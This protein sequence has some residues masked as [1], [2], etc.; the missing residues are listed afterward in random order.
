MFKKLIFPLVVAFLF[1]GNASCVEIPIYAQDRLANRTEQV[2]FD[3][4]YDN[5][6]S[7]KKKIAT[8]FEVS[9]DMIKRLVI[10]GK[11]LSEESFSELTKDMVRNT[12]V[13][14]VFENEAGRRA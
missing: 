4:E 3:T 10:V 6:E 5:I 2:L 9:E 12:I 13:F 1:I 8:Q 11:I 14:V 7:L